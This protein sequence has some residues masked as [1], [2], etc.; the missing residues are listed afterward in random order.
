MEIR[1]L[2]GAAI[3]PYIDDIARLRLT[4]VREFPYLYDSTPAD[5]ADGLRRYIDS[6]RSL[7]IL[8]MDEGR[9]VGVSTGMP[10]G[11]KPEAFLQPFF[12]QGRDPRT[13]YYFG[14]SVLLP[15]YRG[16][17]LGVR[18]FIE[19]ESYAHKLGGFHYC[20][21]SAVERPNGHPRRP[22]DYKPLHAF[23]RNRGFLHQP[24]LR[25]SCAWR[26]LG[27]PDESDK[28]LS[29]WLKDLLL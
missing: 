9:V 1:L 29:F 25:A 19:R 20:A 7:A 28:T 23:W 21:F 11:D 15:A 13:V 17:G 16:R 27:E 26:D 24:S 5:E 12:E 14:K 8:A 2:H 18:F 3:A 6:E 10:L 22:E 4:V